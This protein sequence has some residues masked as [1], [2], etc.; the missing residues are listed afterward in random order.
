MGW[1]LTNGIRWVVFRLAAFLHLLSRETTKNL[2]L[3]LRSSTAMSSSIR[4]PL[5]TV[6]LGILQ[7]VAD[8][9]NLSHC[10]VAVDISTRRGKVSCHDKERRC[11]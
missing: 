4:P 3:A 2:R 1:C 5:D 7:C 11:H 9:A 6:Q 8:C 10:C